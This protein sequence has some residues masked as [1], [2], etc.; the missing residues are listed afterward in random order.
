MKDSELPRNWK[1]GMDMVE[2]REWRR[3]K[4]GNGEARRRQ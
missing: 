2:D 1:T 3:W 4:T